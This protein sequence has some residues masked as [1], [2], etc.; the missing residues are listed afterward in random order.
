[1]SP[2]D[3]TAS[4]VTATLNQRP[5]ALRLRVRLFSS[6][7]LVLAVFGT[8]LQAQTM[9]EGLSA[10]QSGDYQLARAI[11]EP[12][13][14][15]QDGQAQ[16]L[17]GL[18]YQNGFGVTPDN[19]EAFKW[20]ERAAVRGN[21]SAQYNLALMY[22]TGQG[23][24]RDITLA[25]KWYRSSAN[26]GNAVAQYNLG[27]I[28]LI[29][30]DV[31]S[32]PKEAFIWLKKAASQGDRQAQ[33]H[34]GKMYAQGTGVSTDRLQAYLWLNVASVLGEE[35]AQ[36]ALQQ[37]AATMMPQDIAQARALSQACLANNFKDC[38]P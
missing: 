19:N 31:K 10:Y 36:S 11:F 18:M 8:K 9:Q 12:L 6:L 21:D 16:A 15:A 20:F 2:K 37:L 33:Y 35:D 14:L 25:I 34:I 27:L 13:A 7:L 22:E 28:Y 30:K 5:I 3:S 4:W 32:N 24:K 17:L 1:M 29:G 38:K 26:Q 23:A